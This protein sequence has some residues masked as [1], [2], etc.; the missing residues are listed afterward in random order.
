MALASF[1]EVLHHVPVVPKSKPVLTIVKDIPVRTK[2]NVNTS[3]QSLNP[4]EDEQID[5][6]TTASE[7]AQFSSQQTADAQAQLEAQTMQDAASQRL[8]QL[9]QDGTDLR[10]IGKF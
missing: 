5:R 2:L 7:E 6:V 8:N 3:T 1:C 4:E 10:T 9:K